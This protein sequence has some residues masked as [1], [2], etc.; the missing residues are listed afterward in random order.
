MRK[1]IKPELR[2]ALTL[3]FLATGLELRQCQKIW[4][5]GAS[6]ASM[7]VRETCAALWETL[8]PVYM[9]LPQTADDWKTVS[10]G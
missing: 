1:A 9:P 3:W 4:R 6:T 5:I 7:I 10:H 2:L 8:A